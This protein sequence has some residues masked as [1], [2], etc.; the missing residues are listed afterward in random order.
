MH[1]KKVKIEIKVVNKE[2]WLAKRLY[3]VGSHVWCQLALEFSDE[4]NAKEFAQKVGV[5]ADKL[6]VALKT[7]EKGHFIGNGRNWEEQTWEEEI[8]KGDK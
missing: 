3:Q 2:G 1:R 7:R 4:E 8:K 6:I 5:N